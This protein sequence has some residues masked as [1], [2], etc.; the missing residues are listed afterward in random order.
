MEPIP[1]SVTFTIHGEPP[2]QTHQAR[3]RAF[4]IGK[5]CRIVKA[6]PDAKT[7]VFQTS[8][9]Q[10][11][12]QLTSLRGKPLFLGP[13]HLTIY[14]EFPYLK[15]HKANGSRIP[16]VS[17]PDLD[18]MAKTVLDVLCEAGAFKDDSQVVKLEMFKT[19]G[20]TPMV[21]ITLAHPPY[22]NPLL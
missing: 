7:N 17:R 2:T 21:Q 14:F 6:K 8:L 13:V 9:R 22:F 10:S 1:S 18:N 5:H 20:P 15:S 4:R 3:L 19:Y 12:D 16:K 11:L